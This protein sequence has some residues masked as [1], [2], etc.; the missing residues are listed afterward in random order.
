MKAIVNGNLVLPEKVITNGVLVFENETIVS[1]GG[2]DDIRLAADCETIDAAGN[3]IIPGFI[4][5]HCHGGNEVRCE[6]D[7][8][9]MSAHHLKHG[10]TS[11]LCSIGYGVKFPEYVTAI[12]RIRDASEANTPGNIKGIHMESPYISPNFG[13]RSKDRKFYPV[14]K[15]EYETFIEKSRGLIRQ[16]TF[17]PELPGLELFVDTIVRHGIV[18]AMGH[19]QAGPEDVAKYYEKGARI[20]T[21]LFDATGCSPAG[22]AQGGTRDPWL[23][24]CCMTY[25]DMYV[26][27]IPDSSGAHVRP[28]MAKL[29]LKTMGEDY[30]CIITDA[31]GESI[32]ADGLEINIS[33]DGELCGSRMTMELACRNMK[34]FTGADVRVICKLASTNPA[35][36]VNIFDS[37][38]SL[39]PGK[40]ADI[41]IVDEEFEPQHIFLKGRRV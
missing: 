38:G 30:V 7:P 6:V 24:E 36:A 33:E 34:S 41:L 10:T 32:E 40:S 37:V 20:V 15:N 4:D 22:K 35:K 13:A 28:T 3:Y 27:I 1:S 25:D 19:S 14:K 16:W 23:D 39:E 18:P 26:E 9:R 11:M 2:S 8:V 21:H 29:A 17:S 31:S 5:I 12:E